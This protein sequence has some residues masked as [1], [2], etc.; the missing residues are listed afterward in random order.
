M[1]QWVVIRRRKIP[2]ALKSPGLSFWMAISTNWTVLAMTTM[3]LMSRSYGR[4]RG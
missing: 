2:I 1:A 4:G 3:K